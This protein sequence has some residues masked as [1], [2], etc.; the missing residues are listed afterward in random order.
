M[1][2]KDNKS[3]IKRIIG[4]LILMAGI[5]GLF[6]I[7]VFPQASNNLLILLLG[8]VLLIS[9]GLSFITVTQRYLENISR[10]FV[11]CIFIY[12]GFVKAVDPLG[13]QYKFV[14]YFTAWGMD[15]M[16]PIALYLGLLLSTVEFVVGLALFFNNLT[17]LASLG[18]LLFMLI[19]TPITLYLAM[20]EQ[21]SGKELVHDCGCFGDSIILTNW[22][23]FIKNL[24]ILIPVF[25]V[26]FRRKKF[27]SI[28]V[29][30]ANIVLTVIYTVLIVSLS[31]YGLLHL[32]IIDFRPYKI[33]TYIPEGMAIP[34]G[35]QQPVYSDPVFILKKNG[36]TKEFSMESYPTE[37]GWEYVDRKIDLID[38]GY[39]PP[40]HDF[41]ISSDETGDI[42]EDILNSEKHVLLIVAYD[43]T[44]SSVKKQD[45]INALYNWSISNNMDM[46]CLTASVSS[47]I[48]V[49][50]AKTGA[51]YKFFSTDPITLKTIIRSNPGLVLLKKGTV[52]N[53]WHYND[54]PTTEYLSKIVGK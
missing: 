24:I 20:Q 6:F 16:E 9:V 48:D 2:K 52:I 10:I 49:F 42:T 43:L 4:L 13:S 36:V 25:I 12:S 51:L 50:K 11:G 22:Q 54:I 19:F 38:P 30:K 44:K 8:S 39:I 46:I 45:E 29:C 28:F 15:Y 40:I 26:F 53:K 34:E 27:E 5:S 37:P 31:T 41:T 7:D 33:G 18:S 23:T 17:K 3:V 1:N 35:A 47:E 32:P 14:D 21:S